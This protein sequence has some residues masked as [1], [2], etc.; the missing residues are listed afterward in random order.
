LK[1]TGKRHSTASQW[2]FSAAETEAATAT[3]KFSDIEASLGRIFP[4]QLITAAP[5]DCAKSRDR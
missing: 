5:V 1:T 4:I 3:A 2:S